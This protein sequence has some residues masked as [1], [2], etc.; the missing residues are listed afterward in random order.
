MPIPPTCSLHHAACTMQR[1]L[2]TYRERLKSFLLNPKGI[3]RIF[4]CMEEKIQ[5][6]TCN[7]RQM[8]IKNVRSRVS[9]TLVVCVLDKV[10]YQIIEEQNIENLKPGKKINEE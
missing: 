7:Y 1:F 6:D 5:I 8:I 9:C 10:P 3:V 2:K 4:S